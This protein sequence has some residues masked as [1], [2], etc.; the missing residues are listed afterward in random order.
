MVYKNDLTAA[1]ELMLLS[2]LTRKG[3]KGI[4]E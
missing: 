4:I 3:I 1:G 2:C